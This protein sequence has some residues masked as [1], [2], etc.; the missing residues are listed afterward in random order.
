[1]AIMHEDV[2]RMNNNETPSVSRS[3][4]EFGRAS[5]EMDYSTARFSSEGGSL[6]SVLSGDESE[7]ELRSI[8]L[9][10]VEACPV[11][12]D[13]HHC[14][15]RILGNLYH[16]SSKALINSMS[17]SGLVSLFDADVESRRCALRSREA[18]RGR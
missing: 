16:V 2:I 4:A 10:F 18:R 6:S 8:A 7:T 17:R 5:L 13:Q 1:M 14:P 11:N 3:P 15:F 9:R 12:C